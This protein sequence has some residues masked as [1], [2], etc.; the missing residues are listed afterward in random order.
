MPSPASALRLRVS[1]RAT[2]PSAPRLSVTTGACTGA[3]SVTTRIA[4]FASGLFPGAWI[5]DRGQ[6]VGSEDGEEH[7]ERDHQEQRL[8]QRVVLAVHGLQE[9]E[10]KTRV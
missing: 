9:R 2:A 5:Q 7:R 3:W 8:H 6:H 1:P 4:I 10:P